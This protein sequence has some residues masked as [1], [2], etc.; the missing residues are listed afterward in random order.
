MQLLEKDEEGGGYKNTQTAKDFLTR[1]SPTSCIGYISHSN[2]LL[3]PLWAEL[4]VGGGGK[5][6]SGGIDSRIYIYI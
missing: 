4:E 3:Y 6:S 5:R 2:K 1:T